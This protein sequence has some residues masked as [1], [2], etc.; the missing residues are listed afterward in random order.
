MLENRDYVLIDPKDGYEKEGELATVKLITGEFSGIE[1]SYGVVSLD[2]DIVEADGLHVSFEY[3]ILSE[4]KD[5][6]LNNESNKERFE[7]DIS[8]VL[9]SILIE[10][11]EKAEERYTNELREEN[12]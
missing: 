3:N 4:E 1:Y 11:V 12:S 5:F 8:S 6:I 10:T 9:H 2:P 7:N